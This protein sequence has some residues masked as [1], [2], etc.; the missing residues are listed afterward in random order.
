MSTQ[1]QDAADAVRAVATLAAAAPALKNVADVCQT[2][3]GLENQQNELTA[4]N[5]SLRADCDALQDKCAALTEENKK[6][7]ALRDALAAEVKSL[8]ER[9][10]VILG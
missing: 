1:I 8:R 10:S 9:L 7:T 6:Q 4:A 5:A 2:L 3:S